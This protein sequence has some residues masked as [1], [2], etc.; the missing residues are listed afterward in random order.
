[1]ALEIIKRKIYSERDAVDITLRKFCRLW[2]ISPSDPWH[3]I[4]TMQARKLT[5]KERQEE[6][7]KWGIE[8]VSP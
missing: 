2:G 6:L 5:E 1:M 3:G 4:S 8:D 7:R